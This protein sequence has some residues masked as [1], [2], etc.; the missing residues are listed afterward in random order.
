[1]SDTFL[2][3]TRLLDTDHPALQALVR[4]RR[5]AELP[6]AERIGAVYAF[7]RDEIAFGYNASDD[8][9]AS[10]VLEEGYGQC[11]T[12]STLLMALLRA[13]GIP[14]RLRGG[15]V[16]K[17][18]Q[19]GIVE[20]LFYR[21]AP[22]EILH[23]WVEVQHGGRWVGLEGVILDAAYLDG[24]RA[25]HPGARGA[26][27]GYAVGT[28]RLE[29]PPITWEGS[30]TFI[31]ATGLASD[32]G[33]FDDPDHFYA[34]HGTNLGWLRGLLFQGWIRDGM[35]RKVASLRGARAGAGDGLSCSPCVNEVEAT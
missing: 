10:A 31:Q 34:A 30:D 2:C 14:C 15:T 17:R 12:K 26:F 29:A 1:M 19:K 20:G 23:T 13:S 9:P 24:V 11:N 18:L 16:H 22:E 33:V 8:L 7:V 35:N 5:W 6:I 25:A 27:L 3:K 21:L 4:E 28:E 32:F